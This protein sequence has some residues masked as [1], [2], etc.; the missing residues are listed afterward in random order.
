MPVLF[1]VSPK[2]DPPP[3]LESGEG[4]DAEASEKEGNEKVDIVMAR[5]KNALLSTEDYPERD[6]PHWSNFSKR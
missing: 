2:T 1:L 6:Q 5:R 4:A 3:V